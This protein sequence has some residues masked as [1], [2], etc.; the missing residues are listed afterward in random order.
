MYF[1]PPSPSPMATQTASVGQVSC[2]ML[3]EESGTAPIGIVV[4][5]V[6]AIRCHVNPPSL[7]FHRSGTDGPRRLI[8]PFAL[9]RTPLPSV[10]PRGI[11]EVPLKQG[12]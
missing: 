11:P 6:M 12:R 1:A 10:R 4:G 8:V 3:V 7:V 2:P 5:G 9:T